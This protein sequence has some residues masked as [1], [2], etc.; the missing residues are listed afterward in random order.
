M[1]LIILDSIEE[2]DYSS[3]GARARTM[4]NAFT[5]TDKVVS[6]LRLRYNKS[7]QAVITNEIIEVLNGSTV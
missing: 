3:H 4:E 7:R 1:V 2:N 6:Y 5:N